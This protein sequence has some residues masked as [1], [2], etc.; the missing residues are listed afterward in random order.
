MTPNESASKSLWVVFVVLLFP[1][2]FT[3]SF[4]GVFIYILGAVLSGL[5]VALAENKGK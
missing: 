2:A 1:I 3:Q 5:I 4:S